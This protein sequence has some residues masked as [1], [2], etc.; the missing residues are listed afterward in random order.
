M[1]L[2]NKLTISRLFF[3]LAIFGLLEAMRHAAEGTRRI[4]ALSVAALVLFLVAAATDAVDGY[5][6]RK[7]K[8]ATAFG[9]MADP[10]MDKIIIS[11]MLVFFTQLPSTRDEVPAWMVVLVL[12]REFLMTGLRGFIEGG[13]QGFGARLL[14]KLKMAVQC[15]L[16]CWA[17][18]HIGFLAGTAWSHVLVAALMWLTLGLTLGSGLLYVPTALAV[19]RDAKDI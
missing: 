19:F 2:P 9:R 18:V 8:L 6:A 15:A 16:A 12:V 11:G 10:L 17:L 14:G 1:N 5:V 3:A 4:A 13:G 7:K